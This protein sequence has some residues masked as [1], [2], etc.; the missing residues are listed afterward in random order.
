MAPSEIYLYGGKP[1]EVKPAAGVEG[2]I[3][4]TLDGALAF[5]VYH[6][7]E[8]FTDYQIRHD[9]LSVTID[10]DALAS[11]YKVGERD[12]LDHSPQV[13]G[14]KKIESK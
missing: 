2:V 9:D 13:L 14:L 6:D 3:I 5:R 8:Q 4:R 7:R 12:I 10:V 1:A 11:F